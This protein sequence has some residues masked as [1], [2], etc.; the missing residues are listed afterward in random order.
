M[1]LNIK[2][3]TT[4]EL[5]FVYNDVDGLPIDITGATARMQMRRS[6]RS[7]VTIDSTA[8]INGL[9]GEVLFTIA[10]NQTSNI[11]KDGANSEQ[12]YFDALLTTA[13]GKTVVLGE[14]TAEVK[15]A[16]T[17]DE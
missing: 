6:A 5:K 1:K 10:S 12:F 16:I 13:D 17:R 15:L 9:A 3:G 4:F 11:L 14:G 2:T 7:P 8:T